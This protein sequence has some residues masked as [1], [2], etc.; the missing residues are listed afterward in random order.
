MSFPLPRE[1]FL[2]PSASTRVPLQ[3]CTVTK[4]G[5][6][7]E[8]QRK[9]SETS[10]NREPRRTVVS[11]RKGTQEPLLQP[12]CSH[13]A[14]LPMHHGPAMAEPF[15]AS[16]ERGNSSCPGWRPCRALRVCWGCAGVCQRWDK[17][18]CCPGLQQGEGSPRKSRAR[19]LRWAQQLGSFPVFPDDSGC[20]TLN[21][22]QTLLLPSVLLC[23]H[24]RAQRPGSCH[25]WGGEVVKPPGQGL[26]PRCSTGRA[27]RRCYRLCP[28]PLPQRGLSPAFPPPGHLRRNGTMAAALQ[29][30]F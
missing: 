26:C 16:R 22:E 11:E 5:K 15:R 29:R 1:T 20:T 28:G 24:R 18:G 21:G 7:E 19:C 8:G 10:E 4:E 17:V 27:V 30:R 23:S 25:P 2:V 13:T 9:L 14:L 3:F 6:R 12:C